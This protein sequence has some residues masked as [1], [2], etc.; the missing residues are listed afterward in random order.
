MSDLYGP[1]DETESIA[2]IHAALDAGITLLERATTTVMGHNELLIRDALNGRNRGQLAGHRRP[3][4]RRE[5]LPGLHAATAR[6]GLGRYLSPWTSRSRC[7]D[8]GHGGRNG[9]NKAG[10]VRHIGLS[11]V[12]SATVRRTHAPHPIS[13]V[14]IEYSLIWRG[15]E[16][17]ILPTSGARRRY[18]RIRRPHEGDLRRCPCSG[19]C[20]NAGGFCETGGARTRPLV[21]CVGLS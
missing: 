9:G 1:A 13:D 7:A 14:Q 18:H 2:T 5:E 16:S 3:T 15:I 4:F 17:H 21:R 10:Y 20:E 19:P 12:G 11:E 6:D 8:R